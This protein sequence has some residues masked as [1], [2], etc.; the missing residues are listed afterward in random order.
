MK[1]GIFGG[2]FDPIH[3]EHVACALAAKEALGLDRILIVPSFIGPHKRGGASAAAD[4]RLNM[5]RIAFR[6]YDFVTVSDFELALGGTSY[7]YITCRHF[8]EEYPEA[9][10]FFLVGADM[11]EDFFGWKNPDDI[12][13]RV[14]IAACNRGDADV[15]PLHARFRARFSCDFVE[16]PFRGK[17]VSS[18]EIRV[19]LAFGKR[20]APLDEAVYRYM[21]ARGLY[22]RPVLLQA[23]ALEKEERREHSFRVA[24]LAC[25]RARSCKI[26]EEQALMAAGL[27]DCAKSVPLESPLLEGFVLPENVPSPVVHQFTGAYLAEHLFGVR[28]EAV[29]DAIRYHASGREDMTPLGK[30]IYLADLL[31]ESR[32]FAGV[33]ELRALFWKDLD[34]CLLAALEMQLGYLQKGQK[35]IYELT[36]KAYFWARS[37]K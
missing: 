26:P 3:S 7:S 31:E 22:A 4:D 28:E 16:V 30:L 35:P 5:C 10:R 19:G 6:N 12:V 27:H 20:P 23:L 25:K 18:T 17:E 34:A 24:M 32:S 8:A 37:H 33:E 13:S 15:G 1:V 36:Q 2:S 29:L 14:T 11:L 9:E 21:L